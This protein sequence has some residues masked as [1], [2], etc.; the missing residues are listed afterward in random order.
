MSGFE[1]TTLFSPLLAVVVALVL[2][3]R[4]ALD[5]W[6][7]PKKELVALLLAMLATLPQVL[8]VAELAFRIATDS[9]LGPVERLPTARVPFFWLFG[10]PILLLGSYWTCAKAVGSRSLNNVRWCL[11]MAWALSAFSTLFWGMLTS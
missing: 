11:V 9:L 5:I 7:Q 8:W 4:Y 6:R 1:L 3:A 2:T 10:A